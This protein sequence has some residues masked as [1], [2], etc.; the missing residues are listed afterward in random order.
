MITY[1]DEGTIH[2][3]LYVADIRYN[4]DK[5]VEDLEYHLL[6]EDGSDPGFG[7]VRGKTLKTP[8]EREE[9]QRR[10]AERKAKKDAGCVVC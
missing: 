6:C 4:K 3:G 2:Y 9:E 7:W 5:E 10:E 1:E 8:K